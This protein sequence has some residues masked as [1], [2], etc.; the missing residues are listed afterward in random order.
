MERFTQFYEQVVKWIVKN[1]VGKT[2]YAHINTY[3]LPDAWEKYGKI[4]NNVG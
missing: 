1:A 2:K 4:E 3:F